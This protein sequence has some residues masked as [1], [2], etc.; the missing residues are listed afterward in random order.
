M[1]EM[2]RTYIS[3]RYL[4]V[5]IGA[6]TCATVGLGCCFLSAIFQSPLKGENFTKCR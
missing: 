4:L 5:Y 2:K 1:H 6:A 3:G